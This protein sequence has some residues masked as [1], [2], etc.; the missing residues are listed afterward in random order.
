MIEKIKE[1]VVDFKHQYDLKNF[2]GMEGI[3]SENAVLIFGTKNDTT[4]KY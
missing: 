1:K 3:E 4:C 2:K